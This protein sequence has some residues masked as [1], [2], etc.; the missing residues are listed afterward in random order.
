MSFALLLQ[1]CT[2]FGTQNF[3]E[4]NII[5]VVHIYIFI[6]MVF[7]NLQFFSH[8]RMRSEILYDAVFI[9]TP[10]ICLL[11]LLLRSLTC[12][13]KEMSET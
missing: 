5:K 6:L 9:Y 3:H 4:G 2:N 12:C 7:L 13:H 1:K 10:Q 11:L 8:R